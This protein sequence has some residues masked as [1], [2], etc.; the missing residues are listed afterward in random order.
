MVQLLYLSQVE[1]LME[2]FNKQKGAPVVAVIV[3][4]IQGEGGTL[5]V[6]ADWL[7]RPGQLAGLTLLT[8]TFAY[9]L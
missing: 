8:T 5:H 4:P 9:K 7:L 6:T 2:T 3:E 1:D